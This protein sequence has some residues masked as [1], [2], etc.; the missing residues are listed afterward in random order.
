MQSPR[1]SA[2]KDRTPPVL[3][4]RTP[5]AMEPRQAHLTSVLAGNPPHSFPELRQHLQVRHDC[6]LQ[7][8]RECSGCC[9]RRPVCEGQSPAHA[10]Q[11]GAANRCASLSNMGPQAWGRPHGGTGRTVRAPV[12]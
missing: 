8:Q 3:G 1:A 2:G 10:P 6:G 4:L 11:G 7:L 5:Q 12:A 9:D